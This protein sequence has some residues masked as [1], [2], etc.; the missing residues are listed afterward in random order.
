MA[1]KRLTPDGRECNGDA[2]AALSMMLEFGDPPDGEYLELDAE[3]DEVFVP[4]HMREER[5]CLAAEEERA[6]SFRKTKPAPR[7]K[8]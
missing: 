2:D 7:K 4:E 1:T 8:A 6:G 3:G 5:A